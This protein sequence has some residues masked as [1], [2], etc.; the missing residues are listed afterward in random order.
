MRS[1][2]VRDH[3]LHLQLNRSIDHRDLVL[4]RVISPK[5]GQY[6]NSPSINR[7]ILLLERVDSQVSQF[8]A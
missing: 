3:H 2:L 7:C 4:N 5:L 1:E 8:P 6:T